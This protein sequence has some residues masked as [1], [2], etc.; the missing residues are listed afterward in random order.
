MTRT[1][2]PAIV[3]LA[4]V[5]LAG[6]GALAASAAA[7][8]DA[9]SDVTVVRTDGTTVGP[10]TLVW[11]LDGMGLRLTAAD[12]TV[13]TFA[14]SEVAAIRDAR[15]RDVT[16]EVADATPAN[17]AFGLL[18]RRRT[19]PLHLGLSA[20]AGGSVGLDSGYGGV[21]AV[22]AWFAG[23]RWGALERVH[24]RVQY[25]R[26]RVREPVEASSGVLATWSDEIAMLVGARLVHPRRNNNYSYL[27]AGPVLVRWQERP[28]P[29]TGILAASDDAKLGVLVRGGVI[30]PLAGRAAMDLGAFLS[31]RHRL[32]P[33]D[34]SP[35]FT[36]GLNLAV[37]FN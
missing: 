8:A 14:P 4:I 34:D 2:I 6:V 36:G 26:Q 31:F 37:A 7:A 30:M 15:G 25:R 32:D 11:Y 18:G 1:I 27:E 22:G 12:G 5:T 23:V 10:G 19:R 9:W 28:D 35:G 33:A 17:V 13:T 20:D 16:Q 29:G 21:Q 24:L 3:T